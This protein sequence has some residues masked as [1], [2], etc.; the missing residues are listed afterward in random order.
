[1]SRVRQLLDSDSSAV[2]A[3]NQLYTG[4]TAALYALD[5]LIDR[6]QDTIS[7]GAAS[8]D[9]ADVDTD[10][11]CQDATALLSILE[12]LVGKGGRLAAAGNGASSPA[13]SLEDPPPVPRLLE[14][15]RIAYRHLDSGA[16][17]S[18][19]DS[20]HWIEPVARALEGAVLLLVETL[21]VPMTPECADFLHQ[22]CRRNE[23]RM[24]QFMVERLKV[25]PNTRGRQGMT[26][27]Q[28][29]RG[30]ARRRPE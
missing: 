26:P 11:T 18:A 15:L 2:A 28:V 12:L 19:E 27:L 6:S 25:D 16:P 8:S 30:N 10:S 13:E 14:E 5:R 1:V 20:S 17:S 7:S 4:K 9:D 24:A 22:A 23:L 29:R 21:R 3:V